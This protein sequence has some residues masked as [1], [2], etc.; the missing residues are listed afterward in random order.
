MYNKLLIM[1]MKQNKLLINTQ[2]FLHTLKYARVI[3]FIRTFIIYIFNHSYS[4]I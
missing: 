2:T 3:S 4:V 1:P